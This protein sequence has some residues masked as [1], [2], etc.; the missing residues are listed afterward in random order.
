M[1]Y[2]DGHSNGWAEYK[3]LVLHE[4]ETTNKRLTILDKRLS[5]IERNITVLQT[6]AAMYAV[7]IAAIISGGTSFLIKVL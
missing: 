2:E 5:K 6:K 1:N 3:R 4:L 7:G